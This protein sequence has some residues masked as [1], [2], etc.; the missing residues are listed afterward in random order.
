[1]Q[2]NYSAF[3]EERDIYH[4]VEIKFMIVYETQ[5]TKHINE[6]QN[7]YFTKLIQNL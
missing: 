6:I 2:S 1:M 3:Y 7:T 4:C 5:T